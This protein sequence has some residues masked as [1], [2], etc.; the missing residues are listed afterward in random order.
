[1]K[2]LI[3]FVQTLIRQFYIWS[4]HV[5]LPYVWAEQ[6]S[7]IWQWC[8]GF[9]GNIRYTPTK[10]ITTAAFYSQIPLFP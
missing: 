8:E 6:D 3:A 10:I 4:V 7:K 2:K 9:D 1:M 5:A